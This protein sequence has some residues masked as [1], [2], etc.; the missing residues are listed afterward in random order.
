MLQKA[1]D[2]LRDHNEIAFATCEGNLPKLRIF[3]IM[4]QE[5]TVLYFATSALKAV[6][7]ELQANQNVEI[8]AYA[9]Q[10]S[11]RCVG[12]VDFAVPEATKQWIYTHNK[13]LSRLYP[14]YDK[15]VYF[16]LHIAELDY[17]DL[18][19]T[20]PVLKHFDLITGEMGD[21]MT[22]S[23]IQEGFGKQKP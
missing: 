21:E 10:V 23:Y 4:K 20:P 8:L 15:M 17:Y 13:V 3:Q 12:M 11:V 6:W 1:L 16:C 19:P 9:D 14:S 7:R 5:G 18:R 22:M 2:F